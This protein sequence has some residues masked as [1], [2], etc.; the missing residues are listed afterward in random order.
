MSDRNSL[1]LGRPLRPVEAMLPENVETLKAFREQAEI[2]KT[3]QGEHTLLGQVETALAAEDQAQAAGEPGLLNQQR[4]NYITEESLVRSFVTSFAEIDLQGSGDQVPEFTFLEPDVPKIITVTFSLAHA[5]ARRRVVYKVTETQTKGT[6][7]EI[8][9][10]PVEIP[11]I[12]PFFPRKRAVVETMANDKLAYLMAKELDNIVFTTLEA[13]L[14]A[15]FAAA[16][17]VWTYK[18]TDVVGRPVGN[19]K[20]STKGFWPTL[21]ENVIPYF[22]GA[23]K[24]DRV[25][26]VHIRH[27]DLQFVYQVAGIGTQSLGSYTEHQR[28]VYEGNIQDIEIYGHRFRIIP[29]NWKIAS[30]V[31]FCRVGPVAK[32]WLPPM[33]NVTKNMVRDDQSS[34]RSVHRVYEILSP[35]TYWTNVLKSTWSTTDTSA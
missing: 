18:D 24:A 10:E 35:A 20:T 33:G 27:T 26:N 5:S 11:F 3:P 28:K 32:L 17:K 8:Q 7:K 9:T 13:S 4:P 1:L 31:M 6:W 16:D 19:D 23:N 12:N 2:R 14:K 25:I 22:Q 30:G 29:E 15:T 34:V 21:R